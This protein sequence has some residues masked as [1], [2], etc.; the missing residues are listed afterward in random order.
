MSAVLHNV[1]P[2]S[3]L[4]VKLPALHAVQMRKYFSRHLSSFNFINN[5]TAFFPTCSQIHS[6]HLKRVSAP[7]NTNRCWSATHHRCI[8]TLH[9]SQQSQ[10]KVPLCTKLQNHQ[11]DGFLGGLPPPVFSKSE[12][13]GMPVPSFPFSAPLHQQ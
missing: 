2:N 7:E 1:I 5:M 8:L 3:L 12:I 4:K 13:L 6:Q 11:K 10:W 9:T